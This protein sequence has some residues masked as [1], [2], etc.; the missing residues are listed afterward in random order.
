MEKL[1][2]DFGTQ[3][4]MAVVSEFITWVNAGIDTKLFSI[5]EKEAII[6]LFR[7]LDAVLAIFDFAILDDAGEAIPNEFQALLAERNEA[8]SAKD[9]A[10]ADT[11]RAEILAAGYKIIDTKEGSFLERV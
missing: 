7:T 3:E 4:A 9:F 10:R 5:P 11:L 8:K 1:E 6:G 2:D